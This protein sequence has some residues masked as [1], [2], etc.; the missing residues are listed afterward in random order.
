MELKDR[1]K[2]R[3]IDLNLTLEYVAKLVGVTRATVQ[4]YET[5]V[6][7][8]IPSDK[9]ELLAAALQATPAYLMGWEETP[10]LPSGAVPIDLSHLK[11][12]PILGRIQCGKPILAQEE[13]EGYTYTDLNGGAEYFALRIRGDS[14]NAARISDGDIVIVRQQDTVDNGQIAVVMVDDEDATLKRFRQSGHMVTLS[15]QSTNPEHQPLVLD[16]RSTPVR[17][18]GLVVR[19]E[20]SP[21]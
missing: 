5:G 18:L 10:T 19:V 20:F 21:V 16:T 3:R 8:N 7:S 9:I 1:L 2:Q 12:I 14:M 11:R 17:V 4:K 6:I 15:P 13:I